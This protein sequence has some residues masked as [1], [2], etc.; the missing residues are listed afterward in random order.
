MEKGE[1]PMKYFGRIDKIVGVLAS[2][3]VVNTVADVN[4]KIIMTPTSEYEVAE[5]TICTV[6]MPLERTS[7]ASSDSGTSSFPRRWARTW[8]RLYFR[9]GLFEV[10]VQVE[11]G[12]QVAVRQEADVTQQSRTPRVAV[13]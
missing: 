4:R 8:A 13:A 11:A 2:P 10:V 3:G 6:R 7:K 9:R 12:I 5:H 1:E